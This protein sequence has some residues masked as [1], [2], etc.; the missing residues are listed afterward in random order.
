M[1]NMNL[2]NKLTLLRVCMIPVFMIFALIETGFA[3]II[4]VVLFLAASLTDYLDGYIARSCN[5]VTDFGKFMDPIADKLLV[6]SAMVILVA[7]NRMPA[8]ICVVMLAREFIISGFRLVAAGGGKV[9]AAGQL[10][11]LKTVFQMASTIALM[12]LVPVAGAPLLGQFGVV[13]ANVLTYIAA[14]LTIV[15]GVEYI[16]KNFSCISDW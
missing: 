7:Q 10:G 3:Q 1:K 14:L 2:P 16:A 11:K 12:L 15:S 9:I 8:W 6:M 5:L 4:A 13:L